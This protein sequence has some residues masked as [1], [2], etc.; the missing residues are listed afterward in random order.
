MPLPRCVHDVARRHEAAQVYHESRAVDGTWRVDV[1][2]RSFMVSLLMLASRVALML[3]FNSSQSW[4]S[5]SAWMFFPHGFVMQVAWG[6]DRRSVVDVQWT[7]NIANGLYVPLNYPRYGEEDR[8][9]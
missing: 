1:L 9:W 3:C 7:Q 4:T 8:R 6:H 5:M 2:C